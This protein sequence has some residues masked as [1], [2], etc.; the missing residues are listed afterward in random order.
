MNVSF[1]FGYC[2]NTKYFIHVHLFPA[3]KHTIFG[4]ISKGIGVVNRIG[5]VETD[6]GD[7]YLSMNNEYCNS[8]LIKRQIKPYRL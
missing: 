2:L 5:L 3:G 1:L 4:R 7:R 8:G 6:P